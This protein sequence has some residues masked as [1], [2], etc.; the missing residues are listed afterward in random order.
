MCVV[1]QSIYLVWL[2]LFIEQIFFH[3]VQIFVQ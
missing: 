2:I 1:L 3:Y